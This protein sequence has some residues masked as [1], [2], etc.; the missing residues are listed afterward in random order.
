MPRRCLSLALLLAVLIGCSKKKDEGDSSGGGGDD[1]PQPTGPAYTVKLYEEKAGDKVTIV[2]NAWHTMTTNVSGPKG[3]ISKGTKETEKYEYTETVQELPAGA[4]AATKAARAYKV[5]EK[6]ID[7][8]PAKALSY[9]G[10]TVQIQKKG[11]GYTFTVNGKNLPP[12][13]AKKFKDTY[14]KAERFRNEDMLPNKPVQVYEKWSVD[15]AT[16][17]RIAGELPFPVNSDK[18]SATGRL[19]KVYTKDEHQWGVL[20]LK[21]NL[22][23]EANQGGASISG[24]IA[25]ALTLDAPIDA[26]SPAGVMK[27]KMNGAIETK[28]GGAEAQFQLDGE[29]E[30]TRTVAR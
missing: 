15:P 20:E 27:M 8:G 7:G 5:A 10:K 6:K 29:A 25:I 4:K 14:E 26:S 23:I 22:V 1:D 3:K 21:V 2:E 28:Q 30:E 12:D 17:K 19:T 13:E 24:N 18:S 16:M 11:G 9:S